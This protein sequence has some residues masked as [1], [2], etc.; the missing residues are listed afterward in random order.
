[1]STDT[2]KPE[3]T[4]TEEIN[5]KSPTAEP[6]PPQTKEVAKA[7]EQEMKAAF[8]PPKKK[9]KLLKVGKYV[10]VFAAIGMMG[11]H[12]LETKL[13][14]VNQQFISQAYLTGEVVKR[15]IVLSVSSTGTVKPV[16]SANVTGAMT[17]DI[18]SAPF[19][20]GG[21]VQ[22]GQILYQ[23]DT[24]A[25][26]NNIQQAQINLERSVM[27]YDQAVEAI[28]PL[29]TSA[30]YVQEVFVELGET[31]S[32]G[33]PI[34][35]FSKTADIK[36]KI[37]F[38]STLAES[39]YVGQVGYL[40]VGTTSE[41][42]QGTISDISVFEDVGVGNVLTRNVEFTVKN[43]GAVKGNTISQAYV[44]SGGGVVH[45]AGSG[46]FEE[47]L[48][49]NVTATSSGEIHSLL[50]KEGD[51]VS[52]G[53]AVAR[54][55]GTAV[56]SSID[57]ARLSVESSQLSLESAQD[58]LS[59]YVVTAPISGTVIEKNFKAGD[60]LDSSGLSAAGG[61]LAVIYD[62]SHLTFE[63]SIHELDINKIEL[64]QKVLITADAVE[65]GLFSGYVDKINVSGVTAGGMTSYPITVVL[66]E[67]EGLKPGMNVSAEV[68]M[69]S[70]EA[71]MSLP[72]EAVAR[73]E[74]GSY[75]TVC[76]EGAVNPQGQVVNPD[77]T[78]KVYVELG[79]NDS[80]YIQVLSGLDEGAIV[81][82]ENEVVDMFAMKGGP[83]R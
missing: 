26:Q 81:L 30:G 80:S 38:Q 56:D 52:N 2:K 19:E 76:R 32:V 49:H 40:T 27:T 69:E 5:Q 29:A 36:V 64:G 63:M 43:Q 77:L 37:P 28:T 15:D 14:E 54:I 60:T 3:E 59:S 83:A 58:T 75:V 67:A 1:M 41:Q 8:T 42:V 16:D 22:E 11:S 39:F 21:Q 73:G 74:S 23:F 34:A 48:T 12:F 57:N 13:I 24:T 18:I 51:Y 6:N 7:P 68:I 4:K 25:A 78:E 66:E 72:I 71:V 9:S 45:S 65:G 82:W 47:V 55:G 61:N 31:V 46:I 17:G 44:N 35:S 53:S 70:E 62:M 33:T 10:V 20:E 79:I 50:V